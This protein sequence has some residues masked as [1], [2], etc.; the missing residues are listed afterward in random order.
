MKIFLK[1][2]IIFISIHFFSSFALHYDLGNISKHN[3]AA[4]IKK[5][6]QNING[7]P[8]LF[9]PA[10]SPKRLWIIFTGM[11]E[12]NLY[13]FWSWFYNPNE[14]WQ[15]TAYLFLKNYPHTWYLGTKESPLIEKYTQI[16]QHCM[17]ISHLTPEQTFSMGGS[18]GGYA[19]LYYGI[20]LNFKGVFAALPQ[21][22]WDIAQGYVAIDHL[23]D[24]WVDIAVLTTKTKRLPFI[25]I[26][27]PCFSYDKKALEYFL[28]TIQARS[29]YFMLIN[30]TSNPEHAPFLPTKSLIEKILFFFES[31]SFNSN[32]LIPRQKQNVR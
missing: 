24:H 6:E 21:I 26:Q 13:N 27:E 2:V 5:Y 16:I 8:F 4:I 29:D 31:L 28:N 20:S 3:I 25:Y 23:K 9:Y 12:G 10:K 18:M 30:K 1:I 22:N 7:L 14:Q 19:A 15:D 32:D 11:V 17:S